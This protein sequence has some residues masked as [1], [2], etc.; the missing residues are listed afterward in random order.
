MG[1][2]FHNDAAGKE[3]PRLLDAPGCLDPFRKDDKFGIDEHAGE[4][5]MV[6]RVP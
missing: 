5:R 4:N 1:D 3:C 6:E 2:T